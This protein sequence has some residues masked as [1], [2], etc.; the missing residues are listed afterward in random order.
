MKT[1]VRRWL[2]AF[3]VA[4]TVPAAAEVRDVNKYFFHPKLGD[5]EADV[6]AARQEG[7]LGVLLMFEMDDCPF[8]YR[9][10][11][12]VLNQS[13]VQ[14][15]YR[16]HFLIFA[17]DTKGDVPMTDF[18]G[19]QTTEKDFAL[20]QRA[21]ATPVFVFYD[22]TGKPLARY[23]GAT[24]GVEEF[25]QLGRYVVEGAYKTMPFNTYKR[26]VPTAAQ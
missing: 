19:R 1:A 7:K 11:T 13:E 16:K 23:T 4:F 10:K 25:L 15:Y 26:Q 20:E 9:M 5:L 24:K 22:L 21:R 2:L 3:I 12:T 8:C 14:D 17:V 18:A 6:A